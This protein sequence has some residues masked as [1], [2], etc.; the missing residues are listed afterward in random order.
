MYGCL[1]RCGPRNSFCKT[2]LLKHALVQRTLGL[3]TWSIFLVARF[4]TVPV[5][6]ELLEA[7]FAH[8]ANQVGRTS[9]YPSALL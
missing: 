7:V 4:Q 8:L 1:A 3:S 6:F 9:C 2:Q 5:G